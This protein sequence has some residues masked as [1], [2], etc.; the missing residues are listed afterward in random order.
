MRIDDLNRTPV[1]QSAEKIDQMAALL[2]SQVERA[3][4]IENG[5]RTMGRIAARLKEIGSR[6]GGGLRDDSPM[7]EMMR[8][9]DAFLGM[10]SQLNCS[11]TDAN[12]PLSLGIPAIS[13]GT[14][15]QGGGAHTAAEWFSPEGRETGLRRVLLALCMLLLS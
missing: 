13:I 5:R 15:G 12:I 4:E 1:T 7:V 6:P 3:V 2:G 8:A 11:S 9:V 14:G 10:R